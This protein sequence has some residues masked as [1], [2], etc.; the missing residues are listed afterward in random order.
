[1]TMYHVQLNASYISA[2]KLLHTQL[3]KLLATILTNE[4]LLVKLLLLVVLSELLLHGELLV[5]IGEL[6]V[7]LSE[8]SADHATTVLISLKNKMIDY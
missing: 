3:P 8:L 2:W 1:M 6:L 5:L 7:E 4:S